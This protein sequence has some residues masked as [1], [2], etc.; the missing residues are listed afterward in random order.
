[1]HRRRSGCRSRSGRSARLPTRL[2][3]DRR[4]C[5]R[6]AARRGRRRPRRARSSTLSTKRH[7]GSM[8]PSVPSPSSTFWQKPCVVSIVAASKFGDR[9]GEPVA[10]PRTCSGGP[11]GEQRD[12]LIVVARPARPRATRD[13]SRSVRTSR[14]RT[15]SRSSPVAT[16]VKRDEQQ[17]VEARALGDE[18][19]RERR[20]RVRLA[21][22]RRSPR[23]PS[24]RSAAARSGQTAGRTSGSARTVISSHQLAPREAAPRAPARSGRAARSVG[25]RRRTRA[26]ARARRPRPRIENAIAQIASA[27]DSGSPSPR[28]AAWA[29]CG[30][31]PARERQRLDA[32]PR[33]A[34][35]RAAELLER[36]P[37]A[38]LLVA[39]ERRDPRDRD[40]LVLAASVAAPTADRDG[41]EGDLG[42]GGAQRQ[43]PHPGGESAGAGRAASSRRRSAARAADSRDGP[44]QAN[45]AGEDDV[46][47]S[48]VAGSI[49]APWTPAR[50]AIART[51]GQALAITG[52]PSAPG[53]SV[54]RA[55]SA[56]RD[57]RAGR[58]PASMPSSSRWPTRQS[59]RRS[60]ST[61]SPSSTR[62]AGRP[63]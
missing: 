20:D 27:A 46:G 32:S 26:G 48:S 8:S 52:S 3:G 38:L 59:S 36:Q 54:P 15:R 34:A 2:I 63:C 57:A 60:S 21:R 23:A 17:L 24:R 13:S 11:R 14:S 58:C 62:R 43:Q 28:S 40:A 6:S 50:S 16:R 4:G 30:G 7:V 12:D 18:A 45:P 1:M 44:G 10:A 47:L 37:T 33:R 49:P 25:A 35:P 5:G 53:G 31:R 41:L 56:E 39:C 55:I 42:V 9:V 51:S 29:Y 19:R 22:C 61:G